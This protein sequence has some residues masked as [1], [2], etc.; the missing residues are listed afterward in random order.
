MAALLPSVSVVLVIRDE[1]PP[2]A[3]ISELSSAVERLFLDFEF[4]F[5]AN[6]VGARVSLDLKALVQTLPDSLAVFLS[7]R[8][9]ED[10]ARLAGIDHAVSDYVLFSTPTAG[11]IQSIVY[12]EEPLRGG[13]DFVI[14]R[15][16]QKA[17]RPFASRML[18]GAFQALFRSTTGKI[19]EDQPPAFRIMSRAAAL[20]VATRSDGEVL[21]RSRKLGSGFPGTEI[22]L[23]HEQHQPIR[24]SSLLKDIARGARLIATG[25]TTLL[26][27][28]S[29]LAV[30]SGL[31]SALYALYVVLVFAF[32]PDVQPG[33]TTMSLQLSGMMLLFSVQFLLLSEHV[34]QIV[35]NNPT[36]NRRHLIIRELRSPLSRRTRRLNVVDEE[37]RFQL[38]AAA[39]AGSQSG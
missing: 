36:G 7:E 39:F 12:F 22:S 34:I 28:S 21:V 32:Q 23:P 17:F 13:C 14:G 24:P 29:Y 25:S 6:E 3:L 19:F 9:P 8:V 5:V 1:C 18:F 2:L 33:W 27:A 20:Y 26:R 30:V 4:I 31:G 11:E 35:A 16:R 37:G 10:V 38:G 15:S